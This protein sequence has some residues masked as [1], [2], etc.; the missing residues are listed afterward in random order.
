[1]NWSLTYQIVER[2]NV[3]GLSCR[4]RFECGMTFPRLCLEPERWMGS[5]VQSTVGCFLELCF[6]QLSVARVLMGLGKQFINNFVFT[7]WA[8]AAGFDN[9]NNNNN[10]NNRVCVLL[11]SPRYRFYMPAI[12]VFTSLLLT[13]QASYRRYEIR[14]SN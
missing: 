7:T 12:D 14:F 11:L 10:N 6:L 8:C 9:N 4:L 5:R 3:L 2:P 1:M 13:L